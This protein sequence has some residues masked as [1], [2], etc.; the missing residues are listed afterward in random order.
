M[1]LRSQVFLPPQGTGGS[2]ALEPM[3]GRGWM[4]ETKAID[5]LGPGWPGN[6]WDDDTP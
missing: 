3:S 4:R 2:Q 5:Q 1:D 6:W